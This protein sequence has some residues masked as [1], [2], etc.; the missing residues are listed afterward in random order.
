MGAPFGLGGGFPMGPTG[1]DP[2]MAAAA[3]FQMAAA[4][5]AG[6]GGAGMGG[7][8]AGIGMDSYAAAAFGL[9]SMA[10]PFQQVCCWCT[11]GG[12]GGAWLSGGGGWWLQGC[13]EGWALHGA[14]GWGGGM[15]R[16]SL[17]GTGRGP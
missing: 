17:P 10:A 6:G 13:R 1:F 11:A 15:R 4:A 9:P 16:R 14:A 2:A 12:G 3:N 7:I 8:P 5:A